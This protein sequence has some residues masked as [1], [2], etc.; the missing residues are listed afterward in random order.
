MF[1]FGNM[2]IIKVVL[3]SLDTQREMPVC[4]SFEVDSDDSTTLAFAENAMGTIMN[5]SSMQWARFEDQSQMKVMCEALYQNPASFMDITRDMSYEMF[6]LMKDNPAITNGDLMFVLFSI[7]DVL[8]LGAA[9]YNYKTLMTRRI[10]NIRDGQSIYIV[11]DSSLFASM[12]N[13]A[14]EGFIISLMHMDIALVDKK[15]EI[16]GDKEFYLKEHFLK[17]TSEY[18]QKEKLEIFNKVTKNIEDKYIGDD[19]EKKARIKKAV[20][21]SIEEDNLLSVQKAVESAFDPQDEVGQLY[22]DAL[23][24]AGIDNENIQIS[25]S[26]IKRKYQMQKIITESGIELKIPVDYYSD[27]SKLEFISN[28]DG[29]ISL[30]IKDIGKLAT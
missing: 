13:K 23:E 21:E 5:S 16:N 7:E 3:H 26:Q 17:C 6:K 15:Y 27:P 28:G 11:K 1:E 30:V 10:E 25:E 2:E 8:Y 14:D 22:K 24:K 20:V 12:R 29:S 4:S 18:S 9:K 19:L